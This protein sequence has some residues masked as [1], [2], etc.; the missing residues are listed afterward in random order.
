MEEIG[1]CERLNPKTKTASVNDSVAKIKAERTYAIIC[2]SSLEISMLV[3]VKTQVFEFKRMMMDIVEKCYLPEAL[4]SNVDSCFPYNSCM[5]APPSLYMKIC[6][7]FID[8]VLTFM[9]L[10]KNCRNHNVIRMSKAKD[11]VSVLIE[12]SSD[13]TI[14]VEGVKYLLHKMAEDIEKGNLIYKLEVFLNSCLLRGWKD[15]ISTLQSNKF[16]HFWYEDLEIT[17]RCID[18]VASSVLTCPMKMK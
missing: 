9:R 11:I 2:G 3:K 17:S 1:Q 7:S 10:L 13:L 15:S 4:T 6:I 8:A 16:T 14:E 5:S 18:G 12:V